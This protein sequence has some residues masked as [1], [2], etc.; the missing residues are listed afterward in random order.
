MNVCICGWYYHKP[1][2][3]AMNSPPPFRHNIWVVGHRDGDAGKLQKVIIK[4]MGLEFHAY[5]HFLKNIWAGGDTLFI[6]DD[7]EFKFTAWDKVELLPQLFDQ[8]FIHENG[9]AELALGFAHGRAFFCSD[10]F[11]TRLSNDGGFWCDDENPEIDYEIS[12][13]EKTHNRGIRSFLHYTQKLKAN[14]GWPVCQVVNIPEIRNGRRG[15][16]L[17]FKR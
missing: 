10:R 14:T 7:T 15:E 16:F 6:H 8:V 17:N 1:F 5:D 12:T 13:Q 3:G 4:N 11:L 2:I 9:I